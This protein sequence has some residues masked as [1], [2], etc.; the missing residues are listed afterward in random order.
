MSG[1]CH[2]PQFLELFIGEVF[3][4]L[5]KDENKENQDFNQR[6]IAARR[7]VLQELNIHVSFFL[8]KT[9]NLKLAEN[10]FYFLDS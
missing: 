5:S 6:R 10:I 9:Q 7:D 2:Q 8:S 1:V 3:R 4:K